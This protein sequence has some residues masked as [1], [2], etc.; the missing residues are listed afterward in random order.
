MSLSGGRISL[1]GSYLLWTKVVALPA[2]WSPG[3]SNSPA[4][5]F[6]NNQVALYISSNLVIHECTKHIEIYYNFV[7]DEFLANRIRP[8]H[9]PTNAQSADVSTKALGQSQ[10]HLLLGKL[11][12]CNL[13]APTWGWDGGGGEGEGHLYIIMLPI[14]KEFP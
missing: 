2:T 9:I 12:I 5:L 10:F 4:Q 14:C 6:Y 7:R 13:Q 3:S 11:R 8:A 1:H